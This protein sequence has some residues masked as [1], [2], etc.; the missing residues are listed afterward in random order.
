MIRVHAPAKINLYLRICGK[1]ASGYHLIDSLICFTDFGDWLNIMPASHD[2]LII[3][4]PYADA[5]TTPMAG[6]TTSDQADNLVMRALDAFRQAGGGIGPVEITLDKHIPVGAG[7][8]GGSADAAA[9]LGA[10]NQIADRPLDTAAL[11]R[12]AGMLGADIPVCL[13]GGCQRVSNIGDVLAPFT[14]EPV[15]NLVL[16]NPRRPLATKDVF[17]RF[18]QNKNA[19]TGTNGLDVETNDAA[20][21]MK[22]GNDLLAAARGMIEEIDD[23]LQ[24]LRTAPGNLAA[25]MSGSGASCFGIYHSPDQASLAVKQLQHAG[26]WA[27]ATRVK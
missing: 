2:N 23:V 1:T 14:I 25:T 7:L 12:I 3:S 21:L 9:L 26:Y 19:A 20:R 10:L 4:G 22:N 13:A 16:V 18:A 27:T 17:D 8:G 15:S 5:L 11:Y 6:P 24:Q